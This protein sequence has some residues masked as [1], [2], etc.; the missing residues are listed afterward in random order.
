LELL[1]IHY[2]T[3]EDSTLR[4]FSTEH[5]SYNKSLGRASYNKA[6]TKKSGLKADEHRM[7]AITDFA[8]GL[9][10]VNHVYFQM[11][12]HYSAQTVLTC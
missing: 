6:K 8:S 10:S 5:D 7:P 9:F 4:C 3:G 12:Q 2:F 11:W 1:F